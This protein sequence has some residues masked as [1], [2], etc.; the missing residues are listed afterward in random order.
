MRI[1]TLTCVLIP[2][3]SLSFPHPILVH[4]NK[5]K[6]QKF[7]FLSSRFP[8][9]YVYNTDSE[10]HFIWRTQLLSISGHAPIF[11]W[12]II[13]VDFNTLSFRIWTADSIPVSLCTTPKL[14]FS[15]TSYHHHHKKQYKYTD[16]PKSYHI[17]IL[18]LP[19]AVVAIGQ[20]CLLSLL[21]QK[22]ARMS[23][24]YNETEWIGLS[25]SRIQAP[26]RRWLKLKKQGK[27][28][29]NEFYLPN[30]YSSPQST[31]YASYAYYSKTLVCCKY[32]YKV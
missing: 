9:H 31:V 5:S 32:A 4:I 24:Y 20:K 21:L 18:L 1:N 22:M 7:N 14:C 16:M 12:I 19:F 23:T 30:M 28:A 2:S 26:S 8:S 6:P 25:Q 3:P 13:D 11:I 27:W 29:E 15:A 17:S 10:L